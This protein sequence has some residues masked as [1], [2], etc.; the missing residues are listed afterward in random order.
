MRINTALGLGLLSV[1]GLATSA[2]AQFS[3]TLLHNGDAESQLINAGSGLEDFG[4]VARFKTLL[5]S[6]RSGA[7]TDGVLA[8]SAGD[9]FLAGPEFEVG[10]QGGV[11][12]DA[13]AFA[14]LGYDAAAIGNHEFDFGP[15]TLEQFLVA[16]EANGGTTRFVSANLDFSNEPG[17]AAREA[18][19]QLVDTQVFDFGGTMVGVIGAT[20][21]NLPFIASPRG[22]IVGQDVA[23]AVQ[24]EIDALK[25][26]GVEIIILASHL[27]GIDEEAAI[28]SMTNGLDIVIAGGGD[29]LLANPGNTL[30]P[31]DTSEGAYP[32][33]EQDLGG[34]S[35][36]LVSTQD[37][38]KYI[39]RLVAEFDASGEILSVDSVSGPVRVAGG[40]NPDAVEPDAALQSSVVDPVA[41][42]VAAL[43]QVV[44]ATSEVGLNGVTDDV[45]SF[46]TN[47]GNLIADAFL[48]SARERAADFGIDRVDIAIGNSGGIRNNNILP[49]GNFTTLDSF[50]V[51]PFLNFL[52]VVE[53]ITPDRFKLI[54]E[55]SVAAIFSSRRAGGGTGRFG[56]IAGFTVEFNPIGD[57]AE[58]DVDGNVLFAGDRVESIVLDDGT[59]IVQNGEV[60]DGAPS[61][62]LA[63]VD[64]LAR[65]GDQYPLSDLP[66][67]NLGVTY[68]QSL[69]EFAE[70]LGTIS[71]ADYPAGGE[72][73]IVNLLVEC[74]ADTD[75]NGMVDA[76]DFGAWLALF[77]SGNGGA[78][79][80]FSRGI[81]GLDFGAWLS[82]FNNGCD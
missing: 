32:R 28:V 57:R 2:N 55:N 16:V 70:N 39:G 4:G 62:N 75:R 82:N 49:A 81:S 50:D 80:N 31:G 54:M 44:L 63:I 19:G 33:V 69:A 24:G 17:L 79:Q 1:A 73:R 45:R 77:N 8:I 12:Y 40:A 20:T 46:E 47:L 74:P 7:T 76:S 21:P 36:R 3:L 59:V 11:F 67:A 22:V 35:V 41:A 78:D 56:Q 65:G 34:R 13:I 51:L 61:V 6:L 43:D 9:S 66:F 72:G 68:Q 5:D 10:V 42:G 64:F 30:I 14:A 23:M 25:L 71:A 15:D 27:Q 29:N 37:G 48:F 58:I 26:A 60:V 52:T 38:Y 18:A 53:D